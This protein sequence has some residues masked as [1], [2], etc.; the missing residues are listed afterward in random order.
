MNITVSTTWTTLIIACSTL[1]APLGYSEEAATSAPANAQHGP[2]F[3]PMAQQMMA[4][5]NLTDAQKAQLKP[6]FEAQ[7]AKMSAIVKDTT[8]TREQKAEK[9]QSLRAEIEPELGKI[10]TPEQLQKWNAKRDQMRTRLQSKVK[11]TT[12]PVKTP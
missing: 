5:L 9:M 6:I 3:R 8:L 7:R 12:P 2:G 4:D 11:H 10:L 1:L